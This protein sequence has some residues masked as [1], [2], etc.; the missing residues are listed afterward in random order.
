LVH[1]WAMQYQLFLIITPG[2]EDTAREELESKC[3]VSP[4]VQVKGGLEL[5][6]DLEWIINAHCLLKVPTRILMRIRDFKVRDFPKLHQ[7][8]SHFKWNEF[9]SHPEPEW[10]ISCSKSRLMHTGR[11]EETIQ[12]ALKEALIRQPLNLDWQK[13]NYPPQTF[14]IRIVD[15]H[16]TLSLDLTGEALYKRGIQKIKGEAP[17]RENFAA[18]FL[19]DL[20]RGLETDITLV[21]PMC[22]SATFLTETS[23]FNVPIHLRSFAF[24]TAPFF[25]GK[26]VRLPKITKR[27][28]FNRLIGLDVNEELIKK[29]KN[30]IDL[31]LR[32]QDSIN[33]SINID[34]E[35]VMICN[36][37]YGE[38]I[39]I[40]GKR[41]SFLK[42]AWKKFL[43]VDKPLRFGWVLPSD[44]DDLFQE[45]PGYKLLQK[46]HL[47]NG[48]MAVTYWVWE[49]R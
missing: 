39:K 45:A 7:K 2:L 26:I 25:K 12:E 19:M 14:Y 43:T 1:T 16:L 35:F 40:D 20:F 22:G 42:A 24:E 32:V 46:K 23:Y 17:I 31:D 18:A 28:P 29:V 6:A 49:R 36:P 21:D 27:L 38:R 5:T 13:K 4:V 41:G 37:P 9:L 3:P 34:G 47:R 44:M 10:E 15:D 30:E 48:G 33:T 8:F 11:I